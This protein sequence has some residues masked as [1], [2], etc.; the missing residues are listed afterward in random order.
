MR[1]FL[2]ESRFEDEDSSSTTPQSLQGLLDAAKGAGELRPSSF[3]NWRITVRASELWKM[4]SDLWPKQPWAFL[5]VLP[6]APL[7]WGHSGET[8]VH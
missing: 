8:R 4:S 2:L 1:P 5:R 3:G 7:V 6:R